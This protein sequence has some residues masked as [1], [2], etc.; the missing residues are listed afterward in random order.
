MP[1]K[2]MTAPAPDATDYA[3]PVFEE[4]TA[5]DAVAPSGVAQ[6]H[7]G[8]DVAEKVAAA[9][10]SGQWSQDIKF[11]GEEPL[12]LAFLQGAPVDA[13]FQHW[14]HR[15]GRKSFRCPGDGCPLCALGD[16]RSARFVFHVMEFGATGEEAKIWTSGKRVMEQLRAIDADP[17]KGGPLEEGFFAVSRSGKQQSTVYSIQRVSDLSKWGLPEKEALAAVAEAR[18]TDAP[19]LSEPSMELLEEVAAEIRRA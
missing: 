17:R 3:A 11:D 14:I 15:E 4:E 12:L 16:S 5:D 7:G 13:F 18:K 10:G 9:S 19:S 6:L 1:I 8:W 2:R